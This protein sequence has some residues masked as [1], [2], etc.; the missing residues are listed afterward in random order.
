MLYWLTKFHCLIAFISWDIGQYVHYKGLLPGCDV[1]NFESNFIFL[2]KP[3]LIW[4]KIQEK[5]FNILRTRRAF[6]N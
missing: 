3:F 6:S 2:S 4:L 1:I 5:N